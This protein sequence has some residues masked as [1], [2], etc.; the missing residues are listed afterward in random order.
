[1]T[2]TLAGATTGQEY[3][4]LEREVTETDKPHNRQLNPF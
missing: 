1:M 3:L 4:P 2:L